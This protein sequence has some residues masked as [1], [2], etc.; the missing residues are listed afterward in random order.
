[1]GTYRSCMN[2]MSAHLNIRLGPRTLRSEAD[3]Q[4]ITSQI[5]KTKF[6]RNHRANFKSVLRK[7]VEMVRSNYEGQF[8]ATTAAA[9][10]VDAGELPPRIRTEV[11][12]MVRDTATARELKRQYNGEC[13]LCGNRLEIL[14]DEYYP[15]AHQ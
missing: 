9:I 2:L 11:S 12:R 5:S 3:V 8:D 13:Q 7:Y 14:H 10:D 6:N 4:R 1:T 15:E